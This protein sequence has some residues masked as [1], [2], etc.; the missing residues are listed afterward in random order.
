MKLIFPGTGSAF[1]KKNYQTCMI[2]RQNE[3]N[4][5]I[6]AGTT[7]QPALDAIKMDYKDIDALYITHLH[8][9]HA[10][11]VEWLAF[12]TYFDPS[13]ENKIQLFGNGELLRK[14]WNNTWKGGLESVQGK[15][16]SLNDYFDVNMIRPN[17]SFI[18]EGIKFQIVQSV[19]IMNGYAIVPTYGLMITDPETERKIYFTG[20]TQFNPNQ[21]MDFY[22][23]S[24]LIIQDC[25]TLPFCSGV[26]ANYLELRSDKVPDEVKQKMMFVHYQDNVLCEADDKNLI[27]SDEWWKKLTDDGFK[28]GFA[29]KGSDVNPASLIK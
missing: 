25:E 10:G 21:I 24:D 16:L 9:D 23:E 4:F 29:I 1:A 14:G 17:D 13:V 26:H 5:L 19:H 2:I 15:V 20:D 28:H 18:W 6:D 7:A 12:C 27:V 3:K 8:A 11:G 22:K